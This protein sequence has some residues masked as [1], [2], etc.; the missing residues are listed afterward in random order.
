MEGRESVGGRRFVLAIDAAC[1]MCQRIGRAVADAGGSRLEVRNLRDVE[2]RHMRDEALPGGA[3]WAPTL[4]RVSGSQYTAWT[5]F[6]LVAPLVWRLGM[7]RTVR[8][9]VAL[10]ELNGRVHA[11][12]DTNI[13]RAGM[14]SRKRFISAALVGAF[15]GISILTAGRAIAME[16]PPVL[17]SRALVGDAV[18]LRL[19]EVLTR[20]DVRSV[21]DSESVHR[22]TVAKEVAVADLPDGMEVVRY[23]PQGSTMISDATRVDGRCAVLAGADHAFADGNQMRVAV[24]AFP[25]DRKLMI[26]RVY[27]R[28]QRDVVQSAELWRLPQA[29]STKMDL[30][31]VSVNG[32]PPR[33]VTTSE[34]CDECAP[35]ND[36]VTPT[37][38][39]FY[40]SPSDGYECIKAS[41][42]C[43]GCLG[44]CAS[45]NIP[46]FICA[47]TACPFVFLECCD[48]KNQFC[49]ACGI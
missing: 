27:D 31:S 1:S 16:A 35:R 6:R 3:E 39:D 24:V 25:Q 21:L 23:G 32:Q 2:V 4:I 10:G 47:A 29:G 9:L 40:C 43:G 36:G 15:A 7:R 30:L 33:W 38:T 19:R 17:R 11:V 42:A 49:I 5:G 13:S 41:A 14:L 26:S 44:A 8:L 12:G 20:S 45:P 46:C 34:Q 28:P 37:R 48:K 18:R 22:L